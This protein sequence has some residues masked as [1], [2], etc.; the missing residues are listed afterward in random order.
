MLKHVREKKFPGWCGSAVEG[1]PLH[2]KVEGLIPDQGHLY[3]GGRFVPLCAGGN[4]S[5][6]LSQI[7][8]SFSLSSSSLPSTLLKKK[9]KVEKKQNLRKGEEGNDR[10]AKL[11]HCI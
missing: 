10:T 5:M 11:H 3:L 2:R 7:D 1:W 6:S 9:K 4:Q 8:V